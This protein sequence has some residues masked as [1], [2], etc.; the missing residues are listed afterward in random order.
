VTRDFRLE[1]GEGRLPWKFQPTLIKKG[2]TQFLFRRGRLFTCT[3]IKTCKDEGCFRNK[4]RDVV[5]ET[6]AILPPE[7]S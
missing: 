4:E 3:F 5:E 6:G 2:N 7:Y 1:I